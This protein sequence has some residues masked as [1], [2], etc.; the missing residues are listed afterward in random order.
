MR[1]CIDF[2]FRHMVVTYVLMGVFFMLF[3]VTSVDL[4]YLLK[5]NIS[6]FIEYGLMVIDDGALR[7]LVELLALAL[8]SIGFFVL[9]ALCERILVKRLM[10]KWVAARA[11]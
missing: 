4:Y 10:A 8:L 6:L 9:C 2:L 3:G 1:H 5:A 7:Q 11:D